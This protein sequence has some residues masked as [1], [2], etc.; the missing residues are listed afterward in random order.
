[1]A[2]YFPFCVTLDLFNHMMLTEML[3][4]NLTMHCVAFLRLSLQEVYQPRAKKKAKAKAGK[5]AATCLVF[6]VKKPAST[7]R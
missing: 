4:T 7:L 2:N 6:T 5:K 3:L 1:M